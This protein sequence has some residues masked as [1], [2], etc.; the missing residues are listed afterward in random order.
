MQNKL[1]VSGKVVEAVSKKA[2]CFRAGEVSEEEKY[3]VPEEKYDLYLNGKMIHTFFC[4]P[5]YLEDLAYGFLYLESYIA[6]AE[7]VR[8]ILVKEAEHQIEVVADKK[9]DVSKCEERE[10]GLDFSQNF[11]TAKVVFPEKNIFPGEVSQFKCISPEE[12]MSLAAAL[13]ER[14][15]RF[16]LTGGVHSAAL[17]KEGEILFMREDVGRHNAVEKLLGACIREHIDTA[18]KRIVF[19]GRVASEILEKA[20]VIG[21]P[22]LIAVSAPT[23]RAVELAE[24]KGI[25]LVGFARGDAF[26][27]YTFP[28]RLVE[29]N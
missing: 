17:A 11:G 27:V 26:N 22:T 6:A 24:E 23:S 21:A 19:S 5:W 2:V 9:N 7:E 25:L 15:H 28:E 10:K 20:A 16:R 29:C 18:D 4:S 8:E 13:D 1:L 3:L 14:S 12:I